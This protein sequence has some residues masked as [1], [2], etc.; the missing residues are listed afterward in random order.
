MLCCRIE[1]TN[2]VVDWLLAAR[3]ILNLG[4]WLLSAVTALML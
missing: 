2:G 1:A 4:E 3:G